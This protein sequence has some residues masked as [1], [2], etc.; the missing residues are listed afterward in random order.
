MG[1]HPA[2]R[3]LSPRGLHFWVPGV[4]G[5]GHAPVPLPGSLRA[6]TALCTP[7]PAHPR[8]ARPVVRSYSP[9]TVATHHPKPQGQSICETNTKL[10]PGESSERVSPFVPHGETC[11]LCVSTENRPCVPVLTALSLAGVPSSSA[12][13]HGLL[14]VGLPSGPTLSRKLTLLLGATLFP[15]SASICQ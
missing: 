2:A 9:E 4:G 10:Y 6:G 12:Q 7:G 13:G 11:H 1:K 3:I 15:N 8:A 14:L 5:A